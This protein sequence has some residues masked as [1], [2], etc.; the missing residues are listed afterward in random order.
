MTTI[1]AI[2][3]SANTTALIAQQQAAEAA[4][5]ACQAMM[6]GYAHHGATVEQM[7][8]YAQCVGRL[9]PETMATG[10]AVVL[11]VAIVLIF[12]GMGVGAWLTR[13]DGPGEM[14]MGTFVGA[15][16]IAGA[17]LVL[18]LIAAALYFLFT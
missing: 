14:L 16:V 17:E 10:E 8:A 15:V 11:K 7:H 9:Y 5:V 1:M 18:F 12:V 2:A 6:P 13:R 3:A 4:R